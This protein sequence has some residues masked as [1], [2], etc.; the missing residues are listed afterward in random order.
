MDRTHM[1]F[2]VNREGF[3]SVSEEPKQ[4]VYAERTTCR[5]CGWGPLEPVL[6]LGEQYLV[7]FTPSVDYTLPKAP[8]SLCRCSG[9]GLL[10]LGHTVRPE[11]LYDTFWYRSS[12]NASMRDA[13]S[14]LVKCGLKYHHSGTWLDIGAND[15]YLLSVLPPS[16]RRIACEPAKNFHADL[17]PHCDDL[18]PTYFSSEHDC[19]Y[20]GA[21]AG[22]GACDVITSAAMFY[23]LDD[24]NQFV[25]DIARSLSPDGVWINQ[26]NDSPTMLRANAFDSICHEHLCY[27]DVHS[28]HAMYRRHGLAILDI[29]YNDVN[30]GSMRVVAEKPGHHTRTA[31]IAEH[32]KPT[33]DD[34]SRFATRIHKWKARFS[35]FVAGPLVER[36]HAW[37]YGASTKGCVLLQYLDMN[38]AF[39]GIADRNALK[40]GLKM[41]G[42]WLNI[43]SEAEMRAEAPPYVVVLPWAF[44][45]EFI[46]R[47][48]DLLSSGT[49]MVF[50][51]PSIEVVL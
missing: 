27:Y 12:M 17:E 18:I 36:G 29:T 24:P 6:S 5:A 1:R 10:Q 13:L 49:S 31:V 21:S 22:Y 25:N 14:D 39:A 11:L 3:V 48:R 32:P 20:R 4:N 37:L 45:S 40:F 33:A 46:N 47:E 28:L 16:F 19:L 38:E 35:D 30:G 9:C 42:S 15:G 8:L 44:K 7:R 23:D 2:A 51:L 41:S 34:C 43:T 50:P 26:L